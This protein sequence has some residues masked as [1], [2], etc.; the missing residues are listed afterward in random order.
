[1]IKHKCPAS[2][3]TLGVAALVATAGHVHA[4][5]FQISEQSVN[6]LGRAFA[7]YGVVGDDAS[8][9]FYN[10]AGMTL[11]KGIQAEAGIHYILPH[12]EFED[13]GSSQT[14]FTMAPPT[15]FSTFA[16]QGKDK[17]SGGEDALVPNVYFSMPLTDRARIGLGITAPFGLRT[18]YDKDWIGRFHGV[19]SELKTFDINPAIAYRLNDSFSIGAG[20][21][22]QYADATLS[23]AVFLGSTNPDDDGFAEVTADDWGFGFNFGV[24]Y[25]YDANTRLGIGY[26]SKVRQK[27][28]GERDL[29]NVP[30]RS[31]KV[32]ARATVNLPETIHIGGYHRFNDMFA[33][34]LGARWTKW[35]R[36]DELRI[37]FEDGSPDE[38]TEQNW[39]DVWM[40]NAGLIFD[41][42]SQLSFDVGYSYEQTPVRNKEFRTPR[43]PDSKRNWVTLG[44]TYQPIQSLSVEFGYAHIFFNDAKIDNTIDLVPSTTAPS[45]TF[46]DNL[47]G[48]YESPSTDIFSAQ[49]I[50]QF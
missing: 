5:G 30:G 13:D 48:E 43:I 32:D 10:P 41:L 35:S 18:E 24:M 33:L 3:R 4:A 37:K 21:S 12:G 44:A 9:I 39:K 25:E 27:A 17:D 22:A 16:T 14:L 11:L 38:V 36:F 7:G 1:M 49:V 34:A 40:L 8:A 6:G 15:G 19:E 2:V 28:E 23:R 26:R 45:G 42:N 29:R 20:F 31:G 46:T 50:Y 47:V